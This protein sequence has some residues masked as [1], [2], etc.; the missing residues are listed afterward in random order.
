MSDRSA[1]GGEPYRGVAFE[2][3]SALAN[4]S[5]VAWSREAGL[6][7]TALFGAKLL[8]HKAGVGTFCDPQRTIAT[9]PCSRR[10]PAIVPV[11]FRDMGARGAPM[12]L[13]KF[14]PCI[15]QICVCVCDSD[16]NR[17]GSQYHLLS[18]TGWV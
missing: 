9:E 8:A 5:V 15:I 13:V 4:Q 17:G 12:P 2:H 11:P 10:L 16:S 7:P 18:Y 6:T 14:P 1:L 3:G